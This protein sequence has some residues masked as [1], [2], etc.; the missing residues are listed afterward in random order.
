MVIMGKEKERK[1]KKK[2]EEVVKKTEK[3]TEINRATLYFFLHRERLFF[4]LKEGK[5]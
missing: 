4:L 1:K 5:E 2:G 3:N